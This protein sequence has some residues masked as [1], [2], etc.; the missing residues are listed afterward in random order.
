MSTLVS[1]PV[2]RVGPAGALVDA[3]VLEPS[4]RWYL[5]STRCPAASQDVHC[6]RTNDRAGAAGVEQGDGVGP[7]RVG[8]AGCPTTSSATRSTK[9]AFVPPA[10]A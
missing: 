2:E 4:R 7:L 5:A 9:A 6:E 1:W 3:S 10:W 8:R